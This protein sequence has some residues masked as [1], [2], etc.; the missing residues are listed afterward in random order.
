MNKK[1]KQ[2][3]I[4]GVIILIIL[5]GMRFFIRAI[6]IEDQLCLC[7][8]ESDLL[9]V[10]ASVCE[11]VKAHRGVVPEMDSSSLPLWYRKPWTGEGLFNSIFATDPAETRPWKYVVDPLAVGKQLDQLKPNDPLIIIKSRIRSNKL[12]LDAERVYI[13]VSG[14]LEYRDMI[15]PR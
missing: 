15:T 5:L 6:V 3:I 4:R 11:Y 9:R 8:L 10:R 7:V 14:H 1:V 12:G 13:N 2:R